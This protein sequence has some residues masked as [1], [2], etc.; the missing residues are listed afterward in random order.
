MRGPYHRHA[1]SWPGSEKV[2]SG[3][4]SS[5]CILEV[6]QPSGLS[7]AQ[8]GRRLR[9]ASSLGLLGRQ[10]A[11]GAPS[12]HARPRDPRSQPPAP[13]PP[14]RTARAPSG[15]TEG[16]KGRSR[17]ESLSEI[18]E[19]ITSEENNLTNP[20]CGPMYRGMALFFNKFQLHRPW[21]GSTTCSSSGMEEAGRQEKI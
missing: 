17:Q 1:A 12:N 4:S 16:L 13:L 10:A 15:R 2:P 18:K 19:N 5:S 21:L 14:P 6:R 20:E 11:S 7:F 9:V 8:A 3:S